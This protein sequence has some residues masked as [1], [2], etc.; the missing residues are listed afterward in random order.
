MCA[1]TEVQN[2]THPRQT[3][4]RTLESELEHKN[5]NGDECNRQLSRTNESLV[6]FDWVATILELV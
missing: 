4:P 5:I 3:A 2:V 1:V 6:F